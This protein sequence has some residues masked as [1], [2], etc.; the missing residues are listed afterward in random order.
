MLEP[1]TQVHRRSRV[2]NPMI[3]SVKR[4]LGIGFVVGSA[5]GKR[6]VL[7]QMTARVLNVDCMFGD[8]AVVSAFRDL[9]SGLVVMDS[10]VVRLAERE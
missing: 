7:Q 3:L 10:P 5:S 8:L 4:Q 2:E 9:E 1:K 6:N